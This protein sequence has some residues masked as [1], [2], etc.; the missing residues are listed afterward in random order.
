MKDSDLIFGLMA[1]FDK[2]AYA[3][4]DLVYLTSPF[5]VSVSSLRTSLSRM[6][7]ANVI[8]V[9]KKGR[10]AFY[11]FA[12]KGRRISQNVS[13]GFRVP[14]WC[15]W[16]GAFWG[17]VF[18]VPEEHG[19]ARHSIRKKLTMYRFA[20]LNPGFW[21]RPAHPEE[22]IPKILQSLL[23]SGYCRLI[24]FQHHSEFTAE[25]ANTLW[26]LR[27]INGHFQSGL[28]LLAASEKKIKTH[29]PQQA[30]VQK[31]TVGDTIVNTLF[32]DPL[33]PPQ[34]LPPAWAGQEIREAFFHFD[35]LATERSEPYWGLLFNREDCV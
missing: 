6:S 32:L 19:E 27:E 12:G 24:R 3:F 29:S 13:R 10:K 8:G 21:I 34:Y 2:E 1:S 20:C 23:D 30:L 14:N 22:R 7:A 18:S 15:N 16:D 35:K 31:M 17:V 28:D 33:L 9:E 11:R 5:G 4:D 26:N 25:H